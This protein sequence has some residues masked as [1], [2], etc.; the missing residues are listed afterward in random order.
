MPLELTAIAGIV[1]GPGSKRA[2]ATF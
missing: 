2:A 1:D